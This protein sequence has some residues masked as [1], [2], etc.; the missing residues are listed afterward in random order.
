MGYVLFL[1]WDESSS[2]ALSDIDLLI[3][4]FM[5]HKQ[6]SFSEKHKLEIFQL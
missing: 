4:Y 5:V 2:R 6:Y 3:E 1:N